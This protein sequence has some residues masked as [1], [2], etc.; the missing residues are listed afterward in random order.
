VGYLDGDLKRREK[1]EKKMRKEK[2]DSGK[3]F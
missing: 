3:S 1:K 2:K